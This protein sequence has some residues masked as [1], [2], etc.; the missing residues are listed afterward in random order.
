MVDD[1][2]SFARQRASTK[3]FL[4][5][6]DPLEGILKLRSYKLRANN[7]EVVKELWGV[8]PMVLANDHHLA[9]VLMNLV[10]N[11][12]QAMSTA[13]EGGQL[14]VKAAEQD[15]HVRITIQDN[16]PGIAPEHLDK[17]FVPFFTTRPGGKGTG[18][19]LS[20]CHNLV[21]DHGGRIRVDGQLQPGAAFHVDLP[22]IAGSSVGT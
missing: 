22:I 9:H 11:A 10:V 2:S 7:I 18:L 6:R 4:D 5:V 3:R 15:D 21:E 1:L 13:N 19:S 16:G 12:E 20:I 17:V 8:L 14:T